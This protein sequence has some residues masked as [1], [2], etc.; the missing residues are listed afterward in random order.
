MAEVADIESELKS[1]ANVGKGGSEA[2]GDSDEDEDHP[3]RGGQR[4]QCAQS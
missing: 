4:V 3:G 1:R 2:Y